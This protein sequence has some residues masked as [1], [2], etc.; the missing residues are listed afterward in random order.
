M[1]TEWD[2]SA[3][4]LPM[5]ANLRKGASPRKLRL[6]AA[7]GLRLVWDQI[8]EFGRA[9]IQIAEDFAD[10]H[11]DAEQL[12]AARLACKGASQCAAWYAAL[13]DPFIAARNASLSAQSG[14]AAP[15]V[16]A[17]LMRDIFGPPILE[18]PALTPELLAFVR[19]IY[20]D[21][22]FEQFVRLADMLVAAGISNEELLSHLRQAGQHVR[23]CWAIDALLGLR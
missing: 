2:N 15:A 3:D 20:E 9:A 12:R 5:L 11:A 18:S 22:T 17:G 23:G 1:Q 6:F 13:S 8:D 19:S 21:R 7:A 14:G 16:L 10:G 4:P